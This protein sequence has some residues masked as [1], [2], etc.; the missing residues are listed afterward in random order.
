MRFLSPAAVAGMIL[1]LAPAFVWAQQL[2]CSPCS[3]NFGKV[4]IGSSTSYSFLLSNTGTRILRITSIGE[5][6]RAFSFGNISLPFKLQ[7]GASVSLPVNF[8]PTAQEEVDGLFTLT[9]ND[10]R[11][12]LDVRVEGSGFH[13][14]EP[15]L[16]VSPSSLNFGNVTVGSSASMQ[17]T[18]IATNKAVTI[19]SD[20]ST[21]PVFAILG[22]NLPVTIAAGHS[23]QITIQFTPDAS[24]TA[25]GRAQFISN[26]ANSPAREQLT[27]TGVPPALHNV[28]LSWDAGS[29]DP[30]GYNV[31]RGNTYSGPFQ[32]M[33]TALLASTRYTDDTADSGAT[34][35][36]VTTA[37]DAEGQES[38]YSNEVEVVIP[39]S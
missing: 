16:G 31:Y 30:V 19:S 38:A 4:Q 29:G 18:L 21:S 26:A 10:P 24:G 20:Q 12:P 28:D 15:E 17:A 36:Y 35:Y 11:S 27:G 8:K 2:H 5:K 39:G 22:I 3:H 7:P 37:V 1:C 25:S 32:I 9:S 34:Y 14:S 13:S 6:G 33:N 23:L